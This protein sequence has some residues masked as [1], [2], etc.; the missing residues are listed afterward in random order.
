MDVI[1]VAGMSKT[2][3]SQFGVR[4]DIVRNGSVMNFANLQKLFGVPSKEDSLNYNTPYLAGIYLYNYLSR[5]GIRSGLINFLDDELE[6]FQKFLQHS[7]KAVALSTTFLTDIRSVKKVTQIIRQYAPDIKI[8]LGGPL[9]FNS[10]LLYRLQGTDYDSASCARDYFFLNSEKDYYRDIDLF[11]IEEQGEETLYRVLEAIRTRRDYSEIPNLAFYKKDRL[12]V[13][14]RK[15]E[16]NDFSNDLVDWDRVP[17]HY[18]FPVFPLRGSRGCPYRCQY[19]NFSPNRAFRL[20]SAEILGRE[21]QALVDTKKV[22]FIRFT[23]DNLF[24]TPKLVEAYCR[25]ILEVG[26]G[27]RWSS[28]IRANSISKDTIGLLRDSGCLSTM[29]GMES[30]NKAILAGMNKED[31]P[32]HYLEV[33]ELLNTQGIS[34]QLTFIIGYPGE[35]PQTIEDTVHLIN[36]FH[37]QGPAINEI[38]IFPFGLAPLSPIFSPENR[39]KNKLKGYMMDWSHETMD[40]ETARKYAGSLFLQLKNVHHHYGIAELLTVEMGKLKRVAELRSR[41]RRGELL[42]DPEKDLEKIWDDLR[43]AVLS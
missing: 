20:K 35:T 13:N 21:I 31:T 9:V 37:Y 6:T 40:S 16:H 8:L 27:I 34:T 22:K 18:L 3:G 11:I 42:R 17:E 41:I 1:I 10:Y 32:E 7:P 28:F 5:R 36:Q 2:G 25:K 14:A 26:K 43:I 33:V 38:S 39:R 4:L 24:L 30:G 12:T 19:C 29:I 23:D 15:S